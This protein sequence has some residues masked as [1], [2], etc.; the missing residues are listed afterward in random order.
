MN[1]QRIIIGKKKHITWCFFGFLFLSSFASSQIMQLENT[2][3]KKKEKVMMEEMNDEVQKFTNQ[4]QLHSIQNNLMKQNRKNT[5]QRALAEQRERRGIWLSVRVVFCKLRN[6]NNACLFG[7]EASDEPTTTMNPIT[8]S[9]TFKSTSKP[10]SLSS[11][12]PSESRVLSSNLST[13]KPSYLPT[14]IPTN[15]PTIEPSLEPSPTSSSVPSYTLTTFPSMNHSVLPSVSP[16]SSPSLNHSLSPSVSPSLSPSLKPSLLPSASPSSLPSLNPSLSPSIM[17]SNI[18]STKPSKIPSKNPSTLP[19]TKPSLHFSNVPTLHPISSQDTCNFSNKVENSRCK[20]TLESTHD[21]TI[22]R[23]IMEDQFICSLNQKYYFGMT[24][25]QSLCLC[26]NQNL[27]KLWCVD[28]SECCNDGEDP[29]F[30]LEQDGNLAVY[31]EKKVFS[32]FR[33]NVLWESDTEDIA[34][35]NGPVQLKLHNNG[36]LTLEEISDASRVH[37]KVGRNHGVVEEERIYLDDRLEK[38]KSS[39]RNS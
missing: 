13:S 39:S 22:Y 36:E 25:D 7:R 33:V 17:P 32:R 20:N 10:L 5:I 30:Q 15:V 26:D 21:D 11:S 4:R 2:I 8:S 34:K 35:N 12:H 6:R 3:Q 24:K 9:P 29:Y 23:T 1:C 14:R 27:K 37:W 31:S 16:S 38:T 19:T 28:E 18:P